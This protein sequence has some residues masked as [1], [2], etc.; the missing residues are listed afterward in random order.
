[1]RLSERD[2]HG[3]SCLIF[4]ALNCYGE[5]HS[6]KPRKLLPL[7]CIIS[8]F[9]LPSCAKRPRYPSILK[10]HSWCYVSEII[11]IW[12]FLYE[13]LWVRNIFSFYG[14]LLA[15]HVALCCAFWLWNL[16]RD[17]KL[18]LRLGIFIP[19]ELKRFQAVLTG[20]SETLQNV[21]TCNA[22]IKGSFEQQ[23]L[24]NKPTQ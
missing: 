24:N 22:P 5:Y 21:L 2:P 10:P 14:R 6:I 23:S 20:P 3:P 4:K 7:R 9:T 17:S 11:L 12:F 13:R 8:L 15:P 19:L 18:S 16:V 1:M